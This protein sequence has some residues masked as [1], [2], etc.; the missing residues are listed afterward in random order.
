MGGRGKSEAY[1]VKVGREGWGSVMWDKGAGDRS[2]L[3]AVEQPLKQEQGVLCQ[4]EQARE[5]QQEVGAGGSLKLS[6]NGFH[7]IHSPPS[8]S[9]SPLLSNPSPT[10]TRDNPSILK[11]LSRVENWRSGNSSPLLLLPFFP[12]TAT[13]P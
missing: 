5:G 12:S 11:G 6:R 4:G 8:C 2:T 13:T 10:Q 7:T 3:L 1:L 9:P